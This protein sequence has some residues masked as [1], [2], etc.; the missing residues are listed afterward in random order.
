[1]VEELTIACYP[2]GGLI[3][4]TIIKRNNKERI[5]VEEELS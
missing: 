2:N 1:M 4:G 5:E 3:L